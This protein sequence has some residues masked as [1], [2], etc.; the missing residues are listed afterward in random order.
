VCLL[1]TESACT[2]NSDCA[3]PLVCAQDRACRNQCMA[4]RDCI[5]GEIC[6]KS[7]VCADPAELDASGDVP[8]R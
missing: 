3:V 7:G 4:S 8:A 6:A 1:A 5:V 2:Y